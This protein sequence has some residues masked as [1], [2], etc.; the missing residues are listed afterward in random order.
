MDKIIEA[1]SSLWEDVGNECLRCA[2][3]VLNENKIP[4]AATVGIVKELVQTA[5]EIDKLNLWWSV[6]IH[7]GAAAFADTELL[8]REFINP[9]ALMRKVFRS[10]IGDIQRAS[11]AQGQETSGR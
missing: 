5:I 11:R 9:E 1:E 4:T 2:L 8:R 10:T 3:T 7:S 6:H